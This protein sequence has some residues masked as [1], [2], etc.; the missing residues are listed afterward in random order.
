MAENISLSIFGTFGNPNG[1]T[2]TIAGNIKDIKK[3]D[4][5]P[6]AIQLFD[7]TK[8]MYAIR[9]EVVDNKGII[10]F[11]KYSYSAEQGSTRGGTFVGASIINANGIA[12]ISSVVSVLDTLHKNLIRNPKNVKDGI[13]IVKHSNEFKVDDIPVNHLKIS[14]EAISEIDFSE[15]SKNL[16]VFTSLGNIQQS[17]NKAVSLLSEY[18]T[19]Y[20]TDDEDVAKYV[21]KKGLY[22]LIQEVV[23]AKQFSQKL[24]DVETAK[25]LRQ[26]AL[27]EKLLRDI[28]T[29]KTDKESLQKMHFDNITKNREIH[30]KNAE[31]I[32]EAERNL[33]KYASSFDQ[34]IVRL[35]KLHQELNGAYLKQGHRK[36]LEKEIVQIH[37]SFDAEKRAFAEPSS[38][39]DFSEVR[40]PTVL[41]SNRSGH[42]EEDHEYYDYRKKSSKAFSFKEILIMAGIVL[43]IG[44]L[45]AGTWHFLG[46]TAS[47]QTDTSSEEPVNLTT[48]NL[49]NSD[50]LKIDLTPLPSGELSFEETEK[51]IRKQFPLNQLPMDIDSVVARIMKANPTDIGKP[52]RGKEKEY[53]DYLIHQNPNNFNTD[54]KL[55]QTENLQ[56]PVYGKDIMQKPES[57]T[58]PDPK[59]T[60]NETMPLSTV[61]TL[62]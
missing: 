15:R 61:N 11:V 2:Q 60:T 38:L 45:G 47:Y 25:V 21:Q 58:V 6:T 34:Q 54:R 55:T 24:Q 52:Y 48:H 53:A 9:K 13:I 8:A 22:E 39:D 20:F 17:L 35:Q 32:A 27:I 46:S 4:L 19:I 7:T 14:S 41:Q 16:V 29:A 33:V 18:D 50:S 28:N 30:R 10:S 23:G 26:K 1:F 49:D 37:S 44:L 51:T 43:L 57:S 36:Q 40:R 5:N 56:I 59:T 3:Y 31:K 42:R 12:D 62:R